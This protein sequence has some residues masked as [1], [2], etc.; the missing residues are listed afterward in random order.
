MNDAT[1]KFVMDRLTRGNRRD[2]NSDN[3]MRDERDYMRDNRNDNR[4]MRYQDERDRRDMNDYG[5]DFHGA[6]KM[7]LRKSDMLEWK[8][9][10]E[11]VDG[12]YG[13]HFKMEEIEHAAQKLGVTY[14]GFT[15]KEF[16]LATNMIYSD[17]A[18]VIKR[19]GNPNEELLFCADM[20][21]AFLDDP[22]GPEGS[23]KLALY[24]YCIVCYGEL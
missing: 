12:T 19:F 21:K 10:M 7:K 11:N 20:A 13:E 17:Y 9:R 3:R 23:E 5:N 1:R 4:D 16:C 24:Y 22:D 6:P 8:R 18:N 14:D 2:Y 15:E